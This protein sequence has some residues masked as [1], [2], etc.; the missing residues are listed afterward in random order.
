MLKKKKLEN[1]KIKI[2]KNSCNNWCRQ[3]SGEG[4]LKQFDTETATARNE[5]KKEIENLS[6]S[7]GK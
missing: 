5:K 1:A 7:E 2:S 6:R 4:G 3:T